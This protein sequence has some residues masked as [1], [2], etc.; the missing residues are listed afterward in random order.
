MN[1][2]A[3]Q[4]KPGEKLLKTQ[5]EVD[6]GVIKKIVFAGDFFIHPEETL[7]KLE[8][9]L[10]NTEKKSVGDRIDDFFSDKDVKLYGV[11]QKSFK[12]VVEAALM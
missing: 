5:I 1:F 3:S 4:K 12:D 11:S 6:Q 10:L 8:A 9:H 7:D 2:E